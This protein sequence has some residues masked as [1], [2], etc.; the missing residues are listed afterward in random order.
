RVCGCLCGVLLE[1]G[2]VVE[3]VGVA[4]HK[5]ARTANWKGH[6]MAKL[7]LGLA[8][9]LANA[10]KWHKVKTGQLQPVQVKPRKPALLAS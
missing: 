4:G 8:I 7:Q 1:G 9:P 3:G 6:A 5:G 2:E 10:L